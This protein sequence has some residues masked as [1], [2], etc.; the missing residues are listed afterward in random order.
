MEEKNVLFLILD[1]FTVLTD[2]RL[3][4]SLILRDGFNLGLEFMYFLNLKKE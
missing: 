4:S 1:T 2:S 3:T